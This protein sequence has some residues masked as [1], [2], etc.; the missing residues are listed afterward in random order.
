MAKLYFRYGCLNSSKTA[1]ML[2]VA[3]NYKEQDKKVLIFKPAVDTRTEKG[4]V[5]SRVGIETEAIVFNKEFNLYEYIREHIDAKAILVDEA[6]F[7]TKEQVKELA[8]VADDFNIPVLCY[9]LKNTY[10][11]G[12]LFDGVKAL[13]FYAD[14][15]E[16]VKTECYFC[17]KK[18]TQNLRVI[19]G[20]PIYEGDFI[21]IGDINKC[22]EYYISTCRKHYFSP[23]L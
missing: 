21:K 11:D 2:M 7:L 8:I 22:E 4:I 5:K 1:N 10:V 3:H 6:Q 13:I 18:A 23:P 20:K 19:D 12:E 15:L 16:E 9:G 14:K 17:S